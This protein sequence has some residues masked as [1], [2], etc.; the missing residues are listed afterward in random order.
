VVRCYSS[1]SMILLVKKGWF[2][3]A[4]EWNPGLA[5]YRC[6]QEVIVWHRD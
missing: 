3:L 2:G 1:W 5:L 4:W 6:G